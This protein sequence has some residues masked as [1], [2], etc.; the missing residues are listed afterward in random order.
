LN[1]EHQQKIY[2]GQKI[3]KTKGTYWGIGYT[4][5]FIDSNDNGVL[6]RGDKGIIRP[7]RMIAPIDGGDDFSNLSLEELMAGSTDFSQEVE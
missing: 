5:H 3:W 7:S 6:D 2:G 4:D 1:I